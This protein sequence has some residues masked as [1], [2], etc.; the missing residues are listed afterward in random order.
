MKSTKVK[1]K[2]QLV[3]YLNLKRALLKVISQSLRI[4]RSAKKFHKILK[5]RKMRITTVMMTART[6]LDL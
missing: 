1:V 3:N 4:L 5:I 6:L 2:T